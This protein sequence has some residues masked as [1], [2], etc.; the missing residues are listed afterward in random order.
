MIDFI[1]FILFLLKE[2][3]YPFKGLVYPI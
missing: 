1:G 3:Y 2:I